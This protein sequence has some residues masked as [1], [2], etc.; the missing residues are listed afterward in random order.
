MG[1]PDGY[2]TLVGERGQRL[3]D[4]ERQ[5]ISIAR[6]ILHDPRILLLD[7]ATSALD[8]ET[9]ERIHAALAALTK[10]RTVIAIAHRLATLSRAHQLVVLEAGQVVETG[11]HLQRMA[12]GGRYPTMVEAQRTLSEAQ[13]LSH[14]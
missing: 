6:A 10:N 2:D 3:S 4:G 7:E 13:T 1:F 14:A 12:A 11:S 8:L 5:R 9:E